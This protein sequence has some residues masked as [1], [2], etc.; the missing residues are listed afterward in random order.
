MKR[1]RSRQLVILLVT[2]T[3]FD[4]N[5]Y[6]A[7][8]RIT[9]LIHVYSS[10]LK[11]G[12]FR[13]FGGNKKK[14]LYILGKKMWDMKAGGMPNFRGRFQDIP[15]GFPVDY[16]KKGEYEG[17][18]RQATKDLN[19]KPME[20]GIDLATRRAIVLTLIKNLPLHG[21]KPSQRVIASILGITRQMS[22]GDFEF[23]KEEGKI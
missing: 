8:H 20:K 6:F 1:I 12:Y 14:A 10:G 17:K 22:R 4:L 13:F 23:L 5:K 16:S 2:P 19:E 18:K 15:P 7:I 9:F 11:R 21:V 3:F